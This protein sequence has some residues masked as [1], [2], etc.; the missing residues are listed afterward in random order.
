MAVSSP[1]WGAGRKP[2]GAP[3]EAPERCA[4]TRGSAGGG[5]EIELRGLPDTRTRG[6][7]ERQARVL[8]VWARHRAKRSSREPM[9]RGSFCQ[10]R[11]ERSDM[12]PFTSTSGM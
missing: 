5:A 12:R 6:R 10:R 7:A 1:G 8:E 3:G 4:T 9:M 11:N 2:D